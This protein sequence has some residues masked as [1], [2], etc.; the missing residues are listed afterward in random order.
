MEGR[1]GILLGMNQRASPPWWV[2]GETPLGGVHCSIPRG[3]DAVKCAA[4]PL[5]ID[6]VP[7]FSTALVVDGD[8]TVAA[9]GGRRL[10][11]VRADV[12]L[13]DTP[14]PQ[15]FRRGRYQRIVKP[16]FDAL[17]AAVLLVLFLPALLL[18]AAAV[19]VKLGKRVIYRQERTGRDGTSFVMYKFRTM[20]PDRR[21]A[22]VPFEGVDRRV[23][24]KRD[25]DPRHTPLGRF[26]RRSSLDELPQ[27][28]NVVMGHMSLVGPR[29]ELPHVVA[30]YEPW[31]H[32]RHEVKPGLTG[33]WQVSDRAGGLAHEGV[34]LDIAY[35]RQLS[36]STDVR[37]LLRTV[38]VT[39]RRTGR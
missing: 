32:Q 10:E 36:F 14:L 4:R 24:H 19:R 17:G 8:G 31:Q 15:T 2:G 30:G 3:N 5:S 38:P 34:H 26:L 1:Y 6:C 28:W 18:V 11:R 9:P 35:L 39:L 25:D 13:P 37:V 12:F 27:L 16:V 22:Q 7:E 33:F 29:P 20:H 21:R 23:S